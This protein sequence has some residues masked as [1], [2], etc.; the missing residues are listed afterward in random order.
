MRLNLSTLVRYNETPGF[1]NRNQEMRL[2]G[3]Q[4]RCGVCLCCRASR[5]LRRVERARQS[6]DARHS[7]SESE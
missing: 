5:F 3:L 4:C 1:Q 2:T 7:H 6:F